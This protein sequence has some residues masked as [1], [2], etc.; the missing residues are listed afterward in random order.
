MKL[1]KKQKLE[2]N[3]STKQHLMTILMIIGLFTVLSYFLNNVFPLINMKTWKFDMPLPI[4]PRNPVGYDFRWGLY[5]PVERILNGQNIYFDA[6]SN[7]PPF[8]NIFF[9]PFQLINENSAYILMVFIL[10]ITNTINLYISTI[11]ITN[12]L[13][14]RIEISN[15]SLRIFFICVFVMILSYTLSSY[16]FLFSVERGNYDAIAFLFILLT[17]HSIIKKPE[18]LWLHV[19]LLSIASHLKIYPAALFLLLFII[20]GKNV[21]IPTLVTNL[22]LLLSLGFNNALLFVHV[23]INYVKDPLIWVGNHSGAGFAEKLYNYLPILQNQ[24]GQL[25][26]IFTIVPILIWAASCYIIIKNLSGNFRNIYLFIVSVPLMCVV[27]T[28]SHDYKLVILSS[29]L[30]IFLGLLSYK[31]ICSSKLWDYLQLITVLLL[32]FFIGRS[33]AYNEGLLNFLS[34]KY[35]LIIIF[36]LI[37]M[38]NLIPISKIINSQ[39]ENIDQGPIEDV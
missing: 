27:P 22:I 30:L 10:L 3:L 13:A 18:A 15:F 17:T 1:L 37:M 9:M 20:H 11:I 34:N 25:K 7:Y 39:H 6:F 26:P 28:V 33:F 19:V 2:I 38:V 14:P 5:W 29:G 16:P 23:M 24:F 35:P 32:F 8:V 31:I 36:S 4:Q 21:I 12:L